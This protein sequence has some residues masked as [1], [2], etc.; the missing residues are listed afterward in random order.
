MTGR[1]AARPA[2]TPKGYE[3]AAPLPPNAAIQATR[4]PRFEGMD[5]MFGKE[6]VV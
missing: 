6:E 4:G 5:R 1:A 2:T 3:S